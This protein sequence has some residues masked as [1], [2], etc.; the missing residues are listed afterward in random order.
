MF[1]KIVILG[2]IICLRFYIFEKFGYSK[3]FDVG[4]LVEKISGIYCSGL[5]EEDDFKV[6]VLKFKGL[7]VMVNV[8]IR[9]F[10]KKI[11]LEKVF[12]Y[13]L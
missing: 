5:I 6:D 2:F 8:D 13:W 4:K 7:L 1:E 9:N 3:S 11:I 12:S 10:V